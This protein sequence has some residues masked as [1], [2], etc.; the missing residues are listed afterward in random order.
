[1]A[2]V[3]PLV[4]NVSR[5]DLSLLQPRPGDVLVLRVEGILSREQ[6]AHL[7]QQCEALFDHTTVRVMVLD[8]GMQLSVV[9]EA[10][11]PHVVGASGAG[12]GG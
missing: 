12:E 3:P 6:K 10:D 8:R 2:T 5:A 7:R 1:M 9:R 11:T 4:L